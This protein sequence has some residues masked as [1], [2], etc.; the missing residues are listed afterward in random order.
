MQPWCEV[1]L[2]C[3]KM[4]IA[5]L[6]LADEF[7]ADHTSARRVKADTSHY[8][9]AD[10]PDLVISEILRIVNLVSETDG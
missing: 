8:V 6:T 5:A 7:A 9:H 10:D 2:P 4:Q 3:D 1:D